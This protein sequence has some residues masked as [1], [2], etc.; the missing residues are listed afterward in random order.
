MKTYQEF[1]RIKTNQN[2]IKRTLI[3]FS[4]AFYIKIQADLQSKT[5]RIIKFCY[6][7]N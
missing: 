1:I 6:K 7:K 4:K 2:L 3:I 5:Y